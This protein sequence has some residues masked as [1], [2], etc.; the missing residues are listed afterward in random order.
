MTLTSSNS[1]RRRFEAGLSRP[2]LLVI[3][4]TLFGLLGLGALG[5]SNWKVGAESAQCIM[6]IRESQ[7]GMRAW[8]NLFKKVEGDEIDP[9]AILSPGGSLAELPNCPSGNGYV[10]GTKVPARGVFLVKCP[11]AGHDPKHGNDW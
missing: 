1:P 4:L 5:A 3:L 9:H 11:M 8:Q 7:Q 10:V 6:N 2:E